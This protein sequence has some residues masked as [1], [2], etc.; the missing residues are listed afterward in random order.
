MYKVSE[1]RAAEV[2]GRSRSTLRYGP[3]DRSQ[4][5]PL[6]KA[7]RRLAR[8]HRRWGYRFIHALLQREGWQ[9]N[10]KRAHRPWRE[11]QLQR[12]LRR[13]KVKKLVPKRGTSANRCVNQPV[14]F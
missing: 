11:L 9:V 1:R 2:L 10:L 6:L 7:I 3:A 13:K 5:A 4:E 8:R 14:R 12:P